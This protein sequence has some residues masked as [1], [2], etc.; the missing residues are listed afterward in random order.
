VLNNGDN[1][2]LNVRSAAG[3]APGTSASVRIASRSV[4]PPRKHIWNVG[5]YVPWRA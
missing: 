4:S 2:T 3:S 5:V 1:A